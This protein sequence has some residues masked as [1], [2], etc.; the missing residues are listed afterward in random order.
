[1]EQHDKQNEQTASQ[2]APQARD[3]RA[4]KTAKEQGQSSSGQAS[5]GNTAD[6][7]LAQGQKSAAQ[8]DRQSGSGFV[9]STKEDSSE[10]YLSEGKSANADFAE[11]G[12]GALEDQDSS[13]SNADIES[14]TSFKDDARLDDGSSRSR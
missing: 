9:G 6:P 14:G 3:P 2:H 13:A 7:T 11:K 1:M 8:T 12:Q 5:D 4:R 10:S